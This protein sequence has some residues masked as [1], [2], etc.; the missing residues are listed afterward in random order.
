MTN[1][2]A[3]P[4]W[5]WNIGVNWNARV[6][7]LLTV[8]QGDYLTDV[9]GLYDG[10]PT[11]FVAGPIF[12]NAD[13]FPVDNVGGTIKQGIS[14][15]YLT[16][17]TTSKLSGTLCILT[18]QVVD[19]DNSYINVTTGDPTLLDNFG[20]PQP[21]ALNNAQYVSIPSPPAKAPVAVI[22]NQA[23]TTRYV[24]G[25]TITLDAFGSIPGSDSTPNALTPNFP[26][27]RLH[28]E[29]QRNT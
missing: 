5:G 15:V 27:T 3:E 20:N 18:F 4:V 16:N 19:Y 6:L 1:L 8:T 29:C 26:I 7:Q 10:T 17:K 21:V 13:P 12:N 14:D 25:A 22:H 2:L 28:V 9:G 23:A 24:P 11:L